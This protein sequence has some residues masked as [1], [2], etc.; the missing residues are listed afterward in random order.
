MG[1]G[2]G[3]L[4]TRWLLHKYFIRALAGVGRAAGARWACE[5]G[6]SRERECFRAALAFVSPAPPS[7]LRRKV[8]GP[9]FT[10]SPFRAACRFTG[11]IPLKGAGSVPSRAEDLN[12]QPRINDIGAALCHREA[13]EQVSGLW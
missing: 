6:G 13:R 3:S 8:A 12:P 9:R 10:G 4:W 2:R 5:A 7:A 1:G 11:A